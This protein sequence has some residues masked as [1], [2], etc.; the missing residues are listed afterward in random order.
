MALGSLATGPDVLISGT[1]GSART[2]GGIVI[3]A[4]VILVIAL[5]V[6]GPYGFFVTP[7]VETGLSVATVGATVVAMMWSI[8]SSELLKII[9][10]F[11]IIVFVLRRTFASVLLL[12]RLLLLKLL[13]L[14]IL[15]LP[16]ELGF[17]SQ[18][19]LVVLVALFEM[20]PVLV[21]GMKVVVSIIE[22]RRFKT[23]L[24]RLFL[25]LLFRYLYVH[26]VW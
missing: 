4:V 6:K 10:P 16:Q 17:P 21:F 20:V 19:G 26:I 8:N 14:L 12:A 15:L 23:P 18:F 11:C 5:F 22:D 24:T 7:V 1:K 9:L 2:G 25:L 3:V 13:L